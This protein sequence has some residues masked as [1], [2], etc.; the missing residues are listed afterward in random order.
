MEGTRMTVGFTDVSDIP[1][2]FEQYQYRQLMPE[3]YELSGCLGDERMD[4]FLQSYN[5]LDA[6]IEIMKGWLK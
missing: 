2:P 3:S 1:L 6:K 4:Y 5:M